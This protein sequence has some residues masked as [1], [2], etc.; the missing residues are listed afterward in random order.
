MQIRFIL[1]LTLIVVV[2]SIGCTTSVNQ[3]GIGF[4]DPNDPEIIYYDSIRN[5]NDRT[6]LVS[7]M[8]RAA[9][10]GTPIS[11][12]EELMTGAG[13][14]CQ[15]YIDASFHESEYSSGIEGQFRFVDEADYLLCVLP[16]ETAAS[17]NHNW[18]IA[19]LYDGRRRIYDIL[20]RDDSQDLQSKQAEPGDKPKA[21]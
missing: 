16:N 11:K 10:N 5:A 7:T 6:S 8:D 4:S 1:F 12:A 13:F 2:A 15:H 17:Q 21:R 3:Y 14:Q 9:P 20:V 18:T 19:I